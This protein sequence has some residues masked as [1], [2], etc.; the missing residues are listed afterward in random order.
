MAWLSFIGLK[1]FN[2]T[3]HLVVMGY[4]FAQF[5]FTSF[6]FVL[7]AVALGV[8]FY[9]CTYVLFIPLIIYTSYCY[10][11][12]YP[13]TFLHIVGRVMLFIKICIILL[14]VI[15]VI[16]LIVLIATGSMQ[17]IIEADR[18]SQQSTGYIASSVINWTS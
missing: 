4:V 11:R 6:P 2:F 17:E 16:Q 15:G 12:L 10:K 3:E 5:T 14:I 13:L 1:K 7:A 18:A 9:V 8:N